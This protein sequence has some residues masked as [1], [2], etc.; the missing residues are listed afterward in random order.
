MPNYY[1]ERRF[2]QEYI[3][4]MIKDNADITATEVHYNVSKKY[5]FSAKFVDGHLDLLEKM[6]KI[7]RDGDKL[8]WVRV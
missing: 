7:N 3:E 4:T 5:G 1:K 8:H 2:A 6:G